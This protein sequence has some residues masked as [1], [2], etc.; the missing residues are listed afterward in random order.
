V[1]A[2]RVVHEDFLR[3]EVGKFDLVVMNP[4]YSEAQAHVEHAIRHLKPGGTCAALLRI[5]FACTK[6][7]RAFRVG[8]PFDFYPLAT[9]PS[10][11]G[12]EGGTDS[13]E[14]AWFVFGGGG[15]RF[16][17]LESAKGA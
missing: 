12:K 7:R 2:G 3:V 8:H 10:F 11:H 16:R 14:Y 9:R 5:G 6:K 4:P 17:V 15:G 1:V 13:C